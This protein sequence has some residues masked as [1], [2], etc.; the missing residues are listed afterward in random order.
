MLE[1]ERL[2]RQAGYKVRIGVLAYERM[3]CQKRIDEIDIEL[4]ELE[5]AMR[6]SERVRID[7]Q[8]EAAIEAAKKET[9]VN[10]G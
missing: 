3:H 10:N 2:K 8:T 1:Q 7:I 4:A 9:E 5:G 6:E